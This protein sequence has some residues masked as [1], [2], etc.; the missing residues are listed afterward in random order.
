M[1]SITR[2]PA[3]ILLAIALLTAL[4]PVSTVAAAASYSAAEVSEAEF[5]VQSLINKKR[6]AAGLVTLKWDPRIAELARERAEY[7]AETAI[8]SHEE[9]DGEDVFDKIA[10]SGITWYGAGEIIAWN[11]AEELD[12]SAAFAVQGWMNS[13]GHRAIILSKGY[14]YV[15]FGMAI[16]E[17]GKRYWAGV[18]LKGPDRTAAWTKM[19][20]V[21][22][23][24]V[25]A[26]TTKVYLRWDG[27][28]TKLQVLTS[29][30]RYYEIA[31]RIDGGEWVSYGTT[32]SE[33]ATRY[34]DRD[35]DSVE[36]RV[37][38]RDRAGNWSAWKTVTVN[39]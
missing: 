8:F 9:A 18:F 11:N 36:F 23:R 10:D 28:D 29:G 20:T 22:R 2:R 15:G 38:A 6:D 26:D 7:M 30:L 3:L 32:T 5:A 39:P 33:T 1:R 25:D 31:R 19:T 27:S 13:S 35:W 16:G 21:A 14:N 4:A 37:R 12:Y 34:W 24:V 17:N